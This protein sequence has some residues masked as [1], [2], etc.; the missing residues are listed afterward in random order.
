MQE[1]LQQAGISTGLHYIVPLHMQLALSDLG[2][3]HG[4]FPVT[5]KIAD[6][7]IS[8]PMYPEMSDEALEKVVSELREFGSVIGSKGDEFR[9]NEERFDLN[10]DPVLS[11]G[12]PA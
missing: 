4:A 3:Q 6:E 2:Y 7:I 10:I 5:E 12:T 8:L 1:H 11:G 9:Q